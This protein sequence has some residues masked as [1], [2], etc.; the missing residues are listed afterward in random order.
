M[1]ELVDGQRG[2]YHGMFISVKLMCPGPDVPV[3]QLSLRRDLDPGAHLEL[4]RGLAA[5]RDESV[6]IVGSGMSFHN[7]RCYGDARF[8]P[9]SAEFDDWL[10]NA[11]ES[12]PARRDALLRDWIDRKSTRLNSSH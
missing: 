10:T 2:F 12:P 8:T 7:M 9:V 11:V 6:L 3:I 5:L 1:D 4:G